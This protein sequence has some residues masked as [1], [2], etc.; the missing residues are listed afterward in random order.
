MQLGNGLSLSQNNA[1]PPA[2]ANKIPLLNVPPGCLNDGT[3]P[4]TKNGTMTTAT[5]TKV[6]WF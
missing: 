5:I 1:R 2:D 4:V 3:F 6:N